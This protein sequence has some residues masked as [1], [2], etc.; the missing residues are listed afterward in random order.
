MRLAEEHTRAPVGEIADLRPSVLCRPASTL[1]FSTA[2]FW[3]QFWCSRQGRGRSA[4]EA[5]GCCDCPQSLH[6]PVL[7]FSSTCLATT[8]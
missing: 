4:L 3:V 5:Q 1:G 7:R 2:V 8:G 6:R